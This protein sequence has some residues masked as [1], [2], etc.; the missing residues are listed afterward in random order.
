MMSWSWVPG[1]VLRTALIG[2][3]FHYATI[4]ATGDDPPFATVTDPH[5]APPAPA[6]SR[7]GL[8]TGSFFHAIAGAV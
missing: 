1:S 2:H 4:V 5:G 3:E 6:G 7:R 8:V